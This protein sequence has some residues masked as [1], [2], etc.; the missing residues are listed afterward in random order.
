MMKR[1]PLSTPTMNGTEMSYVQE[2][3]D[4]NWIA[5]L[6]PHV[7]AFEKDVSDIVG[8]SHAT[9]LSSGTAALH[10]ALK[11]VGVGPSDIV[12]C[13]D[14]TF[15]ATCNPIKYENAIPVFV[16]S[17]AESW[18]MCP[19]ALLK[20]LARYPQAKAV[21][22]VNLYGTPA[23]LDTI[24]DICQSRN[25]PLIEDAAES[26]GSTLNGK[27][28]GSFGCIGILSFNGNKIITT[29]G[30]G[31]LLCDNEFVTKKVAF[32]ATQARDDARH[33]QHS[34]LG[35]N[36]RMSNISAAIGRGQLITLAER[37][38]QKSEIYKTY[39]NAFYEHPWI[40]MNPIPVNCQSN[41]WLS[42]MT[43]NDGAPVSALQIMERLESEHI[44]SRPIW[45]PMSMQPYYKD[46][47]FVSIHHSAIGRDIFSR[48]LCLPS[49]VKMTK[50]EQ[51]YV[52]DLIL[53]M[54]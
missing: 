54:F 26:L 30:G 51:T 12:L 15:A 4:T 21:V 35:Y 45:K 39:A 46:C 27:Q 44:E 53:D 2:A 49:D 5:P 31:M 48:G 3:F 23:K 6:G 40:Q 13:S 18:N 16:D 20:A 11:A 33:Y 28:T 41:C 14:M 25:I 24:L 38:V 50:E 19:D 36:Y 52:C 17:E 47:D 10:M 32:W 1:I 34:E 42:C 37:V 9:A 7:S 29:S 8:V 43:L 22:V